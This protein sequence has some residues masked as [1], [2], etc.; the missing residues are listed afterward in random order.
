MWRRK[1]FHDE[2]WL[3]T[4]VAIGFALILIAFYVWFIL[5]HLERID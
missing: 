5:T 1:I 3:R 2:Q 4:A